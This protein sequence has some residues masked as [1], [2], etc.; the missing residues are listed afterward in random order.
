MCIILIVFGPPNVTLSCSADHVKLSRIVEVSWKPTF[1]E[2]VSLSTE[3]VQG[4]IQ[5]CDAEIICRNGYRTI[6]SIQLCNQ[7]HIINYKYLSL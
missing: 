5:N 1:L 6:V 7:L 4:R 3:E 2:N